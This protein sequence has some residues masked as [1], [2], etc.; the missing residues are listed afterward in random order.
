VEVPRPFREPFY[1]L[2]LEQ[3][4]LFDCGEKTIQNIKLLKNKKTLVVA[5]G[6]QAGLFSGPLFTIYKAMT[7]IKLANELSERLGQPVLPLFYLVSEDHDFAE[8][9]W[10]GFLNSE[11]S[12]EKIV[13]EASVAQDRQPVADYLLDDSISSLLDQFENQLLDTEFK[14]DVF[15]KLRNCYQPGEKFH[16]SFSKWFFKLFKKYGVI[17]FDSSDQRFKPFVKNVFARELNEQIT[18]NQMTQTNRE[19]VSKNYHV[20]IPAKV[21]RPSLFLLKNGRH[22]LEGSRESYQDKNSGKEFSARELLEN[23]EN[24]SPKAALR[25]IVEDTLFPTIAYVGGPGEIAYWGQLKGIY[26]ALDLPMPIVFPRAGF[27]LIEPKT[28]RNAKKFEIL[29]EAFIQNK[30]E[31][32]DQIVHNLVPQ[33]FTDQINRIREFLN[34][35]L[36]NLEK[37]VEK[38]EPTLKNAFSKSQQQIFNKLG[39]IESKVLKAV[40]Q[41]EK[42]IHSQLEAISSAL[43]PGNSLQERQLNIVYFLAKYGWEMIDK[44]Y[45]KID[46]N[47]VDHRMLEL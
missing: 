7:T 22:S 32:I 34:K 17:L 19:L 43:L 2:L 33:E 20:Q 23:P 12:F 24:L 46:L 18:I 11:N 44:I 26:K 41:K 3:N 5:T 47:H 37:R 42:I 14:A 16:V 30:E 25:P 35:E 36:P 39:Q 6:Q 9:Q 15:Q 28:S 4:R 40:Q 27:S 21:K 38:I 10:A 1:D 31:I 45:E 13:F 8:V 29:V